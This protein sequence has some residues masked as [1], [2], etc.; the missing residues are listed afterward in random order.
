MIRF[1]MG[2]AAVCLAAAL[3][4]FLFHSFGGGSI[5]QER[6]LVESVMPLQPAVRASNLLVP[7]HIPL[8]TIAAA[9]NAAAAP[10]LSGT[11]PNPAPSLFREAQINY[12]VERGPLAFAALGGGLSVES[13]LK[14]NVQVSGQGAGSVTQ[15]L[16]GL[17]GGRIG[18]QLQNVRFDQSVAVSGSI[19]A[20]ARP[21]LMPD[22]HIAPRLTGKVTLK[23][24]PL[25]IA[26]VKLNIARELQPLVNQ[27]LAAEI[28]KAEEALRGDDRIV[29]LARQE[30]GR[31]CLSRALPIV[32]PGAPVLF[33]EVKPVAAVAAQPVIDAKGVHLL[34]GLRAQTR[35][36]PEATKPE[37][38]FPSRLELL[39]EQNAG[40]ITVALPIDVPFKELSRLLS[41]QLAGKTYPQDQ[42]GAATVTIRALD[43]TPS[44]KRLL[45]ALQ[46]TIT[47]KKFF[48]LSADGEVYLWGRPELDQATQSLKL[49]DIALDVKSQAAFGLL[50]A[51]ASAAAPY[52]TS[53]IAERAQVDLKPFAAD[54][55]ARIAAAARQ[56]EASRSDVKVNVTISDLNLQDIA[57]DAAILRVTGEAR[58]QASLSVVSLPAR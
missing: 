14:G 51:A 24:V 4:A 40:G 5:T 9:A 21:Q 52:L 27:V 28:A 45:L 23:E 26:G 57:F 6:P 55:K 12:M 43:L 48:G 7:I 46:V 38:P 2:G 18:S 37:C 25:T 41:A 33:V 3:G 29:N 53:L 20:Q 35:I 11:R 30:W 1:L 47:E 49:V 16:S 44:G 58:G 15:S 39:P 56:V 8:Q 31:L 13:A 10:Q 22:W 42:S 36:L 19:S 17:I 54:A 50:G 34:L 32:A